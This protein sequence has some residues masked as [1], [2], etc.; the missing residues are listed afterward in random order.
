[1]LPRICAN[2]LLTG[3]AIVIVRMAYLLCVGLPS[4]MTTSIATTTELRWAKIAVK[5]FIAVN[6]A[7]TACWSARR[8]R[9]AECFA[10]PSS[11]LV[12]T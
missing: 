9:A 6:V 4:A 12:A 10:L 2:T 3:F 11:R 7:W 1:M 5:N 8:W